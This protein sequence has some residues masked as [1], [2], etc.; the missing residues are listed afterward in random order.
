MEFN[1][2]KMLKEYKMIA[3]RGKELFEKNEGLTRVIPVHL[4]KDPLSNEMRDILFVCFSSAFEPILQKVALK[5]LK[6]MDLYEINADATE[7]VI[8][9]QGEPLKMIG[10]NGEVEFLRKIVEKLIDKDMKCL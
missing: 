9:V 6:Y 5:D 1:N 4:R 8:A 3:G 2:L 10:D 7:E